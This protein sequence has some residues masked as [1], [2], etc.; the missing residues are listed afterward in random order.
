MKRFLFFKI[1][2]GMMFVLGACGSGNDNS[3]NNGNSA[4][5]S[6]TEK[7]D[8]RSIS[9]EGVNQEGNPANAGVEQN[10]PQEKIKGEGELVTVYL[11]NT[12][13]V[14]VGTV[15]LEETDAG[16]R[17]SLEASNLPPGIHG[18]HIHETASCV[19]PTFKTAGGHFN[20]TNA[21]HGIDHEEGP[22]AGDLPNIEVGKDGMIK[23]EVIA[24][25]VTLKTHQENSLFD[26]DGSAL[27]IHAKADDNQSQPAGDAGDRIACGVIGEQ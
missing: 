1:F 11:Q 26:S 19:A 14:K 12:E 21:S 15:N 23:E 7:S 27:V 24:K 16:V 3:D 18:F 9:D 22:H 20:P 2:I 13:G 5:G 17:I 8:E 4:S 25:H 6:N 10:N